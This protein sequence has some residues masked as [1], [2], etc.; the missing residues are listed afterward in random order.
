[1]GG[2]TLRGFENGAGAGISVS[3]TGDVNGDGLADVIIGAWSA[4]A[5][6]TDRGEAYV[7][8]G[9]KSLGGLI[10]NLNGIGG[11]GFTLRGFEDSGFAGLSVGM[12]G[13]VNG[14][15]LADL[16][17]GAEGTDAAGTNRGAAYVIFAPAPPA[18]A[19]GTGPGVAARVNVYA[20]SGALR[21]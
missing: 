2:F 21:G 18:Y 14:D 8:F 6:G 15:G 5:L 3:G 9:S 12:A 17:V 19:V 1:T 10:V 7:V 11:Q 13:D 20:R 16:I 4:D